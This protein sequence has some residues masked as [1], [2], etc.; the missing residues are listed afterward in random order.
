MRSAGALRPL[1][2]ALDSDGRRALALLAVLTLVGGIAEFGL[3]LALIDMLRSLLEPAGA[4]LEAGPAL[5]FALAV[6]VAGALRLAVL[7][8]TQRLAFATSHRL[9]VA[10]QRRVMARSWTSHANARG[11][12]PLMAIEQVE[13]V[14]Y[15][16]LLPLLQSAT[17][18]VL[19]LFILAALVRIDPGIALLSAGLLG[20]LFTCSM[21]FFRPRLQEAGF[22]AREANEARIAAIQQQAGA[23]RELILADRRGLA[24]E[25]FAGIDR[26]LAQARARIGFASAAPRLVVE[27]F[28]IVGLTAVAWWVSGRSGGL[29]GSLPALAALGLG[30]QRL[31]P[32]AQTINQTIA[33]LIAGRPYLSDLGALLAEPDLPEPERRPP[34]PFQ[35][36]I[37]LEDIS[38]TYPGRDEPAI[39]GVRLALR[40]GERVALIGRNGSGKS[41][42]ADLVMGLL[43]AESGEIR[44]DGVPVNAGNVGRWQRNVAHVPQAP[45]LADA[46]IAENIAFMEREPEPGRLVEAA[47]AAGLHEF[48]EALPQGYD[49]R[50]GERGI[51]LS[52]GQRQ[53]LALAR[54]LYSPAPLLVL[55]EATSA[56]DPDSERHVL[57]A[58]DALRASGTTVLL[59]AHRATMLEGCDRVIRMEG[60]RIVEDKAAG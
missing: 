55:D 46:S 21:L 29:E 54:A 58:L 36:E 40:R 37:R 17:A 48:I 38:F 43:P 50:I 24:V 6:L 4:R 31:L 32:L 34:L 1:L 60:G 11:T 42:L 59:I 12:G 39:L 41:S 28:G 51:L 7:R 22:G 44:V 45:F 56:L 3:L 25:R 27:T 20:L 10:T 16:V 13:T 30:A 26:R 19:G 47:R 35:G 33:G 8:T 14:L 18:L 5:A 23:M 15:N 9:L 52:G 53:R 2:A 49:T 57:G